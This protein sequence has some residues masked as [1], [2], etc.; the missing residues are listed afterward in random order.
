MR[1]TAASAP[2]AA[3]PAWYSW[4]ALSAF[5]VALDYATK[6]LVLASFGVGEVKEVLPFFSLV[7]ALNPGAAFSFLAGADGWQRW[8]FTAIAV[9]ASLVIAWLL[10]R[11][12]T[13]LYCSG[14]ALILGGAL[15]N[16]FDRLTIGRVVDFLL[17]H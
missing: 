8:L 2:T 16:L 3:P 4:L 10:R 9:V 5:V 14:L 12:G 7:L 15:G 13:R 17:F 11:G 1:L 6:A